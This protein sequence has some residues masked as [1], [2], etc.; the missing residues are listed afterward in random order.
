MAQGL[1][2]YSAICEGV[3]TQRNSLII[4]NFLKSVTTPY[5]NITI[6]P[7]KKT[8]SL[9]QNAYYFGVVIPAVQAVFNEA[10]NNLDSEDVHAFLKSEIG[11]MTIYV[12]MPNGEFRPIVGSTKTMTTTEFEEYLEKIRAWAA[13]PVAGLGVTIALPNEEFKTETL[14]IGQDNEQ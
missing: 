5:V 11:K 1:K 14:Q 4:R 6:T 7:R 10:G 2:I 3:L 13:D 12:R 9:S 8:R